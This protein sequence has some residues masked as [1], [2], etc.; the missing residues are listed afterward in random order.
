MVTLSAPYVLPN[1][2]VATLLFY[3][4]F[5]VAQYHPDVAGF[6]GVWSAA[7]T[8]SLG[9]LLLRE[10]QLTGSTA[11]DRRLSPILSPFA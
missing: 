9:E 1:A 7:E 6:S 2:M 8:A 5:Y 4:S 3:R 11:G 10:K